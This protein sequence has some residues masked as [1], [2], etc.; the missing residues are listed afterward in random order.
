MAGLPKTM[1]G[2]KWRAK[3]GGWES[4]VVKGAGGPGGILT[5]YQPPTPVLA[6]IQQ[7]LDANPDFF[8]KSKS[9][10]TSFIIPVRSEEEKAAA[11]LRM[12]ALFDA[13]RIESEMLRSFGDAPERYALNPNANF[14]AMLKRVA[15]ASQATVRVSKQFDFALPVE[16]T[17][18]IQELMAM[19]GLSE[20]GAKR[21]I[22]ALMQSRGPEAG[23]IK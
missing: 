4:R 11:A 19:H 17:S 10:K 6:L 12:K 18:L 7:F 1:Q 22:D 13:D 16:W 3:N 5:E 20:A 14:E 21:V 23:V 8:E 2:V 9:R 15:E